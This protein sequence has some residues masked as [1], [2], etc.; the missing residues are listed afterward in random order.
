[1]EIDKANLKKQMRELIKHGY[2]EPEDIPSIELYMDQVT[3]FMDEHLM[4]YKRSG[5]DKTLTKTMINN[6]TKND[7]LPPPNKKRYSREHM[8]LLIYIYYLKNIIS[9]G[10]INVMLSPLIENHFDSKDGDLSLVDIYKTLYELEKY[11][12]FNVEKSVMKSYELAEKKAKDTDDE[13]IKKLN[14]LSLLGY[15]NFM[16]KKL[17][18]R[19]IDDMARG[20]EEKAD[21]EK[22]AKEKNDK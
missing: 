11:Q 15:D 4:K 18:E 12:Y 3:T 13:Y 16:K 5:V 6:Y 2:I 1:M 22:R 9:I 7:L 17:M 14:F 10:D 8:I 21:S 19:I 20:Q